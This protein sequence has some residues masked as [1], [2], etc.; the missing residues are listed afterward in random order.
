LDL[1][2][3]SLAAV[4]RLHPPVGRQPH[5]ERPNIAC[6]KNNLVGSLHHPLRKLHTSLVDLR[7]SVLQAVGCQLEAVGAEGV[8]LDDLRAGLDVGTVDLRH[9][10]RLAE[11]QL[12][13]TALEAEAVRVQHGAHRAV[14]QD[15]GWGFIQVLQEFAC[16]Q[17]NLFRKKI[18]ANFTP[19]YSINY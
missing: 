9:L 3:E 6:H 8:G 14:S 18:S 19:F 11:V 7:Q 10:R 12:V 1:L 15:W 2:A 5:T 4:F 13:E 16:A 17:E